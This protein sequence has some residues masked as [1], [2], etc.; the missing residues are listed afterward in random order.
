MRQIAT[1]DDGVAARKLADFL[2]TLHIDT[3]LD[4]DPAGWAI[5]VRDED[6]VATARQELAEFLKN[7]A[8]PR[9]AASTRQADALRRRE[10][11][12][13]ESF[14]RRQLRPR[15]SGPF[16]TASRAVSYALIA[17]CVGVGLY[18][19]MGQKT[20]RLQTLFIAPYHEWTEVEAGQTLRFVR[21]DGLDQIARGKIWRLVTPIFI[22]LSAMHLLFNMLMLFSFGPLVE[23]RLGPL[24]FLLLVLVL[25]VISNLVQYYLGQFTL[26]NWKHLFEPSPLFGGMS[27]VLF[28]L[29][30]YVW[31]KSRFEP[32][33]GFSLH[34]QTVAF[35]MIWLF[36]G[37]SGL[38]SGIANGAHAGGLVGG[39]LIGLAGYW[40]RLLRR[41]PPA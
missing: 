28:G 39:M 36:I 23:S 3:H 8:D 24:R 40:W 14:R 25:A 31:M 7:P 2:L 10:A 9:Y 30:G 22:H 27:G 34:P 35:L 41:R 11:K 1:L 5:W 21:W 20:D 29:F 4:Q 18:S 17:I 32:E 12:A 6:R 26:N 38:L 33:S 37:L 19:N 16:N 15:E 13:E